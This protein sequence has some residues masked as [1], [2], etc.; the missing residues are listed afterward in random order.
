MVEKP[1]KNAH[2][3][4]IFEVPDFFFEKCSCEFRALMET[5]MQKIK[6][7]L[8]PFSRKT[9]NFMGPALTESQVQNND[10]VKMV[11]ST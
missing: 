8:E 4:K 11:F 7:S 2:I 1:S 9:E 5:F 3:H 10:L 6:K